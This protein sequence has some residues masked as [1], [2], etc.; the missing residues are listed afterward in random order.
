[1]RTASRFLMLRGY[2]CS[3]CYNKIPL[4]WS[5]HKQQ[6]FTAHSSGGSKSKIR[7]PV[8]VG[9]RE[10][11]LLT[12]GFS[13]CLHVV[14]GEGLYGSFIR[15]LISLM[16]ALPPGPNHLPKAPS[17]IASHWQM[18]ISTYLFGGDTNIQSIA[19]EYRAML[20]IY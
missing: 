8:W 6:K 15:T 17:P 3:G 20:D 9:F 13:L 12:A 16:R 1:M 7:V 4:I 5:P 11:H 10:D 14:G 19:L 2:L 18:R